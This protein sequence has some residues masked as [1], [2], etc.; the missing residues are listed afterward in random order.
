MA[1]MSSAFGSTASTKYYDETY[2]QRIYDVIGDTQSFKGLT[3]EPIDDTTLDFDRFTTTVT[4]A[5]AGDTVTI[6]SVTAGNWAT[7][8]TAANEYDGINLQAKGEQFKIVAGKPLYFGCRLAVDDATQSDLLVGLAETKTDL[9]NTSVSHAVTSTSVE[10]VF[11]V[12]LDAVTAITARTYEAGTMTNTATVSTALDTSAHTYEITW[13]G[14]SALSFYFDGVIVTT[15]TG[16]LANGDLT[17]SINFRAGSA[18][19]RVCEIS[20]IR[21]FQART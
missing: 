6:N 16:T 9:L 15:F 19:A 20:W 18:V 3:P 13:D 21:C 17:P 10:G 12:K 7:I 11:F 14:V 1:L 2:T 5:G 8:T 4:E